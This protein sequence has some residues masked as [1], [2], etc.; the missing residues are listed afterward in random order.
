MLRTDDDGS[1]QNVEGLASQT[2]TGPSFRVVELIGIEPT[3]S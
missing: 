2:L 3:T 1:S